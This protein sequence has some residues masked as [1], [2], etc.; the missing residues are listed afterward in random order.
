MLTFS[1]EPLGQPLDIIGEVTAEPSGAS[2]TSGSTTGTISSFPDDELTM[3]NNSGSVKAQ[4][5]SLG[6][7]GSSFTVTW[8][9]SS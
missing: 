8:E 4:P 5:G 6:G 1:S 3:I 7:G 2:V 9:R